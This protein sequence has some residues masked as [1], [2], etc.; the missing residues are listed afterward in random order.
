MFG[1]F[2]LQFHSHAIEINFNPTHYA[3]QWGGVGTGFTFFVP[4]HYFHMLICY[5][6]HIQQG[7]LI[8]PHPRRIWV[9]PTH[10]HPRSRYFFFLV[11]VK[12]FFIPNHNVV[13]HYP[14]KRWQR[15]MLC[16]LRRE[17]LRVW[18]MGGEKRELW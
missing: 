1:L 18:D 9:S 3:W 4:I 6:I 14:A 8:D 16:W 17:R 10:P 11:K 15:S 12:V 13:M 2:L 5:S 7:W